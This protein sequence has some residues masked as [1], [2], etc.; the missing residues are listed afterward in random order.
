M[1]KLVL[2]TMGYNMY[3]NRPTVWCWSLLTLQPAHTELWT[4]QY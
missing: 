3:N 1:K 2:S 4:V